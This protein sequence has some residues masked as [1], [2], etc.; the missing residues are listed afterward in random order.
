MV[1]NGNSIEEVNERGEQIL[2][3]TLLV[4][5]NGHSDSVTF[6]LPPLDDRHLWRRVTDTFEPTVVSDRTFRAGVKYP[7][8]GRSIAVFRVT[9]PLRDRRRTPEAEEAAAAAARQAA[10]VPVEG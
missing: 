4:L 3:D 8:E 7:L 6:T 5:L 1:L 9:P 2:G 10:L